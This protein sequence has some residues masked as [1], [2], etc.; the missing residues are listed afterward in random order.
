MII[1]KTFL[2]K[3]HQFARLQKRWKALPDN[4]ILS[5]M[6]HSDINETTLNKVRSINLNN[7]IKEERRKHGR[8]KL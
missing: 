7:Y 5:V 2:E 3:A 1:N 6:E 8:T 4:V